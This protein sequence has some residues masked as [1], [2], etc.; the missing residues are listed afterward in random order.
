[1]RNVFVA[2]LLALEVRAATLTSS[3]VL[4]EGQPSIITL[5]LKEYVSV[6]EDPRERDAKIHVTEY[7]GRVAFGSPPQLFDMVFDTGSGNVVL[8]TAKCS[9]VACQ[10]HRRFVSQDSKTGEQLAYDDGTL[11]QTGEVDRDTTT[12]TYGTGKLTGEYIRDGVCLGVS[13]DTPSSNSTFCTRTDFLGVVQESQFPFVELPFD[14]IFGLGLQG[15]SAGPNFNFVNRMRSDSRIPDPTFAVFLRN[16]GA[17]EDSEITFGGFRKDRL[18]DPD[19]G[20]SWLPVPDD[21]DGKGYWL[22]HLRDIYVRGQPLGICGDFSASPRCKAAM[23][24][25]SSLMMGP[26]HSVRLLLSAIGGCSESMPPLRFEFDAVGGGTFSM[27]LRA[28]DYVEFSGNG[29]CATAFQPID[30]PPSLGPMWVIGQTAL[31]KYYSIYDPKRWRVGVGLAQHTTVPRQSPSLTMPTTQPPTTQREECIDDDTSM[32]KDHL[33]GCKSFK[34]MNYCT[35]FKPLASHYCRRSCGLCKEDQP[36]PTPLRAS[37]LNGAR[38][39]SL[40][41]GRRSS[42]QSFLKS[43]AIPDRNDSPSGGIPEADEANEGDVTI[44]SSGMSVSQQQRRPIGLHTAV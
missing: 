2:A 25:G 36:E 17:E 28:E 21:A 42:G 14:G 10:K 5:P 20:L 9:D 38:E 29:K 26:S 8:P 23:D 19:H 16:L 34:D 44:R 40:R 12:I 22:V 43:D 6:F 7:Y 15:L 24:T 4:S 41:A 30:L 31:R 27:D 32:A 33:P 39:S 13:Y 35:R 11:L 3:I 18:A 37:S 1:L